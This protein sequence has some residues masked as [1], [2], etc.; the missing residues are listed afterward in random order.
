MIPPDRTAYHCPECGA[1]IGRALED[2]E[3]FACLLLVSGTHHSA[4]RTALV[5]SSVISFYF[6]SRS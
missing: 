2:G 4:T 5:L 6:G 1:K 3:A